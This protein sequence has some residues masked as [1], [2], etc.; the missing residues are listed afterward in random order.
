ML[1]S[2]ALCALLREQYLAAALPSATRTIPFAPR[3][4]PRGKS[5]PLLLVLSL[6]RLRHSQGPAAQLLYANGRLAA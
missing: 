4:A 1:K 6:S 5:F 2:S 3:I